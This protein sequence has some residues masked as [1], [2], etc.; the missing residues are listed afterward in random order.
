[1]KRATIPT[2]SLVVLAAITNATFVSGFLYSQ[3]PT[4]AT[5]AG[6]F[7]QAVLLAHNA[8]V[9]PPNSI[10]IRGTLIQANSKQ[11]LTIIATRLEEVITQT[12]TSKRVVT[13]S[14]QFQDDG[15]NT[16]FANTLN[17]FSQLDV[18]SIFLM[19]QLT[20]RAE[21]AGPPEVVTPNGARV[22]KVHLWSNRTQTHFRQIKVS[23]EL[24]V[25]VDSSG[26]LLGLERTFYAQDSRLRY[27]LGYRFSDYR[28]AGGVRLPYRIETVFKGNI[29]ETIL[30]NDYQVNVPV[31]RYQFQPRIQSRSGQ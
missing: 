4:T 30:V 10:Q 29:E 28:N 11:P 15:A 9:T 12:G 20:Q 1:M 17:A 18:T 8:W 27:T 5:D 3:K 21:Q 26:M 24:D 22:T 31:D 16:S 25:F 23:D 7:I 14:K 2:M 6:S 19:A 13:P